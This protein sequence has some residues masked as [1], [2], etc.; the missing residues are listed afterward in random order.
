MKQAIG[1]KIRKARKAKNMTQEQLAERAN[2]SWSF[3]SRIECGKSYPR[4]DSLRRIADALD[5]QIEDFYYDMIPKEANETSIAI[6]N[7]L[8]RMDERQLKLMLDIAG[9]ILT[10]SSK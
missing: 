10:N 7:I 3:I 8:N 4:S 5:A 1:E 6:V 9:C 2:L